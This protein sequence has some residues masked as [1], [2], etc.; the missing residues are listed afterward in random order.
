[1]KKMINL[2]WGVWY[3]GFQLEY[4]FFKSRHAKVQDDITRNI[5]DCIRKISKNYF[6]ILI[7]IEVELGKS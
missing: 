6:L 2:L 1:M 3:F 7:K 5:E 4:P